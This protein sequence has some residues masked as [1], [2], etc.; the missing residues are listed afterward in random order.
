MPSKRPMSDGIELAVLGSW[1][2]GAAG[3][4]ALSQAGRSAWL[5]EQKAKACTTLPNPSGPGCASRASASSTPGL[6]EKASP[7]ERLGKL[8][9][10]AD[11]EEESALEPSLVAAGQAAGGEVMVSARIEAIFQAAGGWRL[12][13]ARGPVEAAMMVN[14]AVLRAGEVA[15]LT[16]AGKYQLHPC[17]SDYFRWHTPARFS[18]LVYPV[19]KSGDPGLGTAA[20]KILPAVRDE[21]LEPDLSGIQPK[22]RAPQDPEEKDF[23]IR[24]DAPG[25]I[26]L[27]GIESP[28]RTSSLAIC[29]H[30]Q[31]M[32]EDI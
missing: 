5:L 10:A 26:H 21:D 4:S 2:I 19:K 22:L 31:Q 25:S 6:N 28:S 8:I 13:T 14:A 9:V 16:G 12:S 23:V 32:L 24:E 7:Y 27:I 20:A 17:L 3:F 29:P 11:A 1:G 18:L 30:V 15:K